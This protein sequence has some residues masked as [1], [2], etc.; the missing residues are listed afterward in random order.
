LQRQL[1]RP[2]AQLL[3]GPT[4]LPPPFNLPLRTKWRQK[5]QLFTRILLT[6]KGGRTCQ[7]PLSLRQRSTGVD[8]A[9]ARVQLPPLLL[10][11]RHNMRPQPTA[12]SKRR[13]PNPHT[14]IKPRAAARRRALQPQMR[15]LA[16]ILATLPLQTRTITLP[17]HPL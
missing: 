2:L 14:Q 1:P 5:L 11:G 3:F 10:V 17:L 15:L 4:S 16:P 8:G 7:P 6:S 13:V 12:G 9:L